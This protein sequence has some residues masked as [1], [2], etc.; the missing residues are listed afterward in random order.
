MGTIFTTLFMLSNHPSQL[1]AR[2]GKGGGGRHGNGGRH[3]GDR[4]HRGHDRRDHHDHHDHHDGHHHYHDHFHGRGGWGGGIGWDNWDDWN[5][6]YGYGNGYGYENDNLDYEDF[7][8]NSAPYTYINRSSTD[9][10][11]NFRYYDTFSIDESQYPSYQSQSNLSYS[12]GSNSGNYRS[13]K[14]VFLN[15]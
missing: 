10:Y 9:A 5:G 12:N 15:P 14:G 11:G 13:Q 1:E 8:Y 4:G 6:N 2:G 3:D 7:S